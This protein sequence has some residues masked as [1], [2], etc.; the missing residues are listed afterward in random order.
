MSNKSRNTNY[1][2][3]DK[4]LA[5]A[6]IP[7]RQGGAEW[8]SDPNHPNGGYMVYSQENFDRLKKSADDIEKYL[9]S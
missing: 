2:I 4:I 7:T 8:V 9:R 3:L 5:D 6:N 1:D